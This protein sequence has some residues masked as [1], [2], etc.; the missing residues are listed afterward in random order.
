[1][2]KPLVI[3]AEAE[4]ELAQACEWFDARRRELGREFLAV[5]SA[6]ARI[7]RRPSAGSAAPGVSDAAVRKVWIRRFKYHVVFVELPD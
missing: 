7:E 5:E 1:L 3:G 6:L 4:A 2:S